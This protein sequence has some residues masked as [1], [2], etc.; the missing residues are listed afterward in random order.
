MTLDLDLKPE[1]IQSLSNRDALVAFFSA[2][3]YNTDARIKQSAA[4]LGI[5]TESVVREIKHIEQ[6]ASQDGLLHLYLFEL[7]SV[8]VALTSALARAFRNKQ[9]EYLLV[10]TSDY[11][12]LDFVLVERAIPVSEAGTSIGEKQVTVRP[13]VLTIERRKPTRRQLRVLRRFTYTESDPYYQFEK[14]K[15]A[16]SIYDWSE[17]HFNNRILF[18]DYYLQERLRDQREWKEDVKPIYLKVRDFM[19]G[20]AH[21]WAGKPE[22]DIRAG[23]FEKV[24]A[25]LGF[26]FKQEKESKD[27]SPTSDYSLYGSSSDNA[28]SVCLCYPWGRSLDG[29]DDQR[30]QDTPE[31]NPSAAVVSI[32]KDGK[33]LW[34]I[35]TNGKLWRLYNA[36]TS[37]VAASFY[38]IDLEEI[39]AAPMQLASPSTFD[40]SDSFKYFS[41]FFRRE[42]FEPRTETVAGEERTTTFLDL[43]FKGSEEY[44]KRLGERL[45]DRVFEEVFIHFAEGFIEFVK[46][47]DG[48]DADLSQE[49]LDEVF[50][51]TLTLLY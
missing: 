45:K 16:Y 39:L 37:S 9:G 3:R 41:L 44:A 28:I 22:A 14:L 25:A 31:E 23:L 29:K 40:L 42:A 4:N 8:T 48:K 17:E 20:A 19:S 46:K 49:K 27:D 36:K 47:R 21:T 11:E 26:T 12:H 51:G 6:I 1:D 34:A 43:V 5:G 50:Q 10:L 15:S 35:V 30:D 32:L 7:R 33:A 38:E 13:H 2:L 18:A 24:F